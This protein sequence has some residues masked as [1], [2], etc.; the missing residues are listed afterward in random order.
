MGVVVGVYGLAEVDG[1]A[2]LLLQHWLTGV[3]R[4]LEQEETGV[5]LRQVVVRRVVL[6]KHLEKERKK[7]QDKA[8]T[9]NSGTAIILCSRIVKSYS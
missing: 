4:N 9:K 1:I 2:E 3:A 8:S 5:G 6:I 7:A